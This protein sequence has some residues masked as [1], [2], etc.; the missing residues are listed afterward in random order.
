[1]NKSEIFRSGL[2]RRAGGRR[3]RNESLHLRWRPGRRYHPDSRNDLLHDL[4]LRYA[5]NRRLQSVGN[6]LPSA[7][8][9]SRLITLVASSVGPHFLFI[10]FRSL[11][12]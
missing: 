7:N 5:Q 4:V 12:L 2:F 1:M 10:S 6:R 11:V 9:E 3:E 8:N